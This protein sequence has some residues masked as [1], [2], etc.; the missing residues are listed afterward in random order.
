MILL[1]LMK[2]ANIELTDEDRRTALWWALS[3][4]HEDVVKLLLAKKRHCRG[5]V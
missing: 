4:A 5:S 1:L 2:R 3:K